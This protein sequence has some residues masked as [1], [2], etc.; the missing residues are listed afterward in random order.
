MPC[1]LNPSGMRNGKVRSYMKPIILL[2]HLPEGERLA[3]I[4]RALFP[5]GMRLRA[6]KKEEYLEPVGYLAGVKELMPCGEVYTGD[7]FEKEMMV[8][9]GLTSKQVDTVILALR[10]TG[11]GRIDYKAVLTPTNQSWNALTLYGELAKEHAK[12]NR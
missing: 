6:V 9:A 12:M 3:K 8:M 11:A 7:D 2:Y 5:L 10:K 4:K 1:G